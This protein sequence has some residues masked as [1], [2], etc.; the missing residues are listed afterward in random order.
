MRL[1]SILLKI[2][3]GILIT[4]FL[5]VLFVRSPWGQNVIKNQ[6]FSYLESKTNST[7][8]LDR[9]Y[10]SFAGDITIEN[11]YVEDLNQDT[12]LYSRSLTAGIPIW[13]II[14]G[15]GISV[16]QLKWTG[17][18]ANVY[19]D[20]GSDHFNYQFLLDAFI[21][22]D[23]TENIS[24]DTTAAP[25]NIS[26]GDIHLSDIHANYHDEVAGMDAVVRVGEFDI[27]MDRVE[28]DS[29]IFE[30]QSAMLSNSHF[31]YLQT[32]PF[33]DSE[34]TTNTL[35]P[36]LAL[37]DI[38]VS[39]V[40]GRYQSTPDGIDADV[41][42]G[43][44][45]LRASTIDLQNNQIRIEK[46]GL[47]ESQIHLDMADPIATDIPTEETTTSDSLV[48]FTWPEWGVSLEEID[49]SDN[50]ITYVTGPAQPTSGQFNPDALFIS[51]FTL[52][53]QNIQLNDKSTEG[54]LNQLHF[55]EKSGIIVDQVQMQW[56]MDDQK[57]N[58]SNIQIEAMKSRLKGH[59]SGTY[60]TVNDLINRPETTNIDLDIPEF[61]VNPTPIAQFV[62]ELQENPYLQALRQKPLT[63]NLQAKGPLA[64]LRIQG[65]GIRWG[66]HTAAF[67]SGSVDHVTNPDL[68]QFNF[69]NILIKTTRSDINTFMS[70]DSLGIQYPEVMRLTADV[71]GS[72]SDIKTTTLL[73]TSLGKV[74]LE[75]RYAETDSLSFSALVNVQNLQLDTLLKN[76]Q[77]GILSLTAEAEGQGHD[78]SSLDATLEA[79][80]DS[81]SLNDYSMEDLLM[82]GSVNN[83]VGSIHSTYQDSNLNMDLTAEVVLDSVSP[84]VDATLDVKDADLASLGLMNQRVK[85]SFLLHA[86]FKGNG[87]TFTTNATLNNGQILYDGTSYP[88]GTIHLSAYVTP[89]TTAGSINSRM[90]DLDLQSNTSPDGFATAISRHIT[91]YLSD[92]TQ[93][94]DTTSQPVHVLVEAS[95]RQDPLLDEVF[96]KG[97]EELDTMNLKVDFHEEDKNLMAAIEV[98]YLNYSGIEIDSLSFSASSDKEHFN[99]QMGLQQIVAGPLTIN[100]TYFRN[101]VKNQVLYSEFEARYQNDELVHLKTETM[102]RNDSILIHVDPSVLVFDAKN[103]HI[104]ERNLIRIGQQ[105]IEFKNF[106]MQSGAQKFTID[107]NPGNTSLNVQFEE[108]NLANIMSYFNPDSLLATGHINGGFTVQEPLGNAGL[109]ADIAI[110]DL[111]VMEVNMGELNLSGSTEDAK[112]YKADLNLRGG[113][114][115]LSAVGEYQTTANDAEVNLDVTIDRISMNAIQSFSMGEIEESSGYLSGDVRAGGSMSNLNY[116]G[117]LVFHDARVTPTM[118]Q[119][120]FDLGSQQ[121]TFDNEGINLNQF[122]ISDADGNKF[123]TN[124]KIITDD[125]TNPSFDLKMQAKDFQILN[126]SKTDDAQFYGKASFN[127]KATLQGDLNLPVLHVEL[128]VN[129]GT[130]VTY[131]MPQGEANLNKQEGIVEFVNKKAPEPVMTEE[132]EE[133]SIVVQGYDIN[134][135]LSLSKNASFKVII[136]EQTGD[137]FKIAGEGDLSFTID[138]TG[139]MSLS[140]NYRLQD[141]HYEM[142]LYNLVNRRFDIAQGSTVAWSGD[143]FDAKLN[144]RAIY[145]IETTPS[146]L[147]ASQTS[148]ADPSVRNQYQQKMPFL[149]YLNLD[150]QLTEPKLSFSLDMPDDARGDMGGQVYGRIQQINQ[151]D[152]LLN[153]QVFSLLVLGRFYPGSGSDGSSGGIVNV[154]RDNLNQALSDQLNLFSDKLLGDTGLELNFGLDSYTDYQG[155]NPQNRTQLDIA[156]K[157]TFLDDRLIV[158]VGSEVDL[159][160]GNTNPQEENPLIGNVS[161]EYLLT[162]SGQF[163]IRGF[164]KNTFENVID[165]QTIISGLALIFTREFN[166]FNEL[167]SPL[168]T[169]Q[170]TEKNN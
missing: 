64:S 23:S 3:A 37:H 9:I 69:P 125:L 106:N 82:K 74:A 131:I 116:N 81:F 46:I 60:E 96:L 38:E 80:I 5:L 118:L 104:P 2:I 154:A 58:L 35:L 92:S 63:G 148:A 136:S 99:M 61:K 169:E 52:R 66:T 110:R 111:Q 108:F 28:L 146:S 112:N 164:R 72:P 140:G 13:P 43:D 145:D 170:G 29:M 101:I 133:Q 49:L 143:P 27:R 33:P 85:S 103:W 79:R 95:L 68:L 44:F 150:G 139:R 127:A 16:N 122:Q 62:P 12:L 70:E 32:K 137:H 45:V 19:R 78:V 76:P 128:D 113:E 24:T 42:I 11:L 21:S 47:S 161:V 15:Q 30:V 149:V 57:F 152:Q 159:E 17:A 25:I 40:T 48:A 105:K 34:T 155:K 100:R 119:T 168:R 147:M 20:Q 158:K 134:A 22:T 31:V 167:W 59:I 129:A 135:I 98:P 6:V 83:G 7:I 107:D 109:I 88:T 160:G 71:S 163:R 1:L 39:N 91:S 94:A 26:V 73:E 165:G 132:E 54:K 86:Y 8:T 120:P 117:E 102:S 75:G 56:Q 18:R 36:D 65:A 138:P 156:A 144:V 97:L 142:N 115:D 87:T 141:G 10:I 162:E 114:V 166:K 93:I 126:A 50:Q 130:N 124:G 67:A 41:N 153:K 151:Q 55:K 77:L 53:G 121:I 14:T 4:F 89:D 123:T 90:L 51:D 84:E 157:K